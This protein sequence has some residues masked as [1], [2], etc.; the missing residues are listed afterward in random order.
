MQTY[1]VHMRN[2]TIL[3][4]QLGFKAFI[5]FQLFIGGSALM[6]LT[7]LLFM[8]VFAIYILSDINVVNFLFPNWLIELGLFN[9]ICGTALVMLLNLLAI[10]KRGS[11][12]M[13][14]YIVTAPFYWL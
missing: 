10:L 1:L 8:L 2:P 3:Y 7:Y 13:V 4:R 11:Y 9:F 14:L 12:D 6:S 5:S